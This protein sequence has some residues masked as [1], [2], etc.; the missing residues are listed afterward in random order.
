MELKPNVFTSY[1]L[2]PMEELTGTILT[3]PQVAVLSNKLA[4]IAE[5]KLLLKFDPSNPAQFTQSEAYERGQMDVIQWLLESSEAAQQSL[6]DG[7]AATNAQY[8]Q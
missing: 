4:G 8:D 2:T 1:E 5:T 6:R 3:P 7:T